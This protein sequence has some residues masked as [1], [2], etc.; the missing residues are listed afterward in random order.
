MARGQR[1]FDTVRDK[2]LGVEVQV[3]II[4]GGEHRGQFS[5][6][7]ADQEFREETFEEL[8]TKLYASISESSTLTWFPI[9]EVKTN[10]ENGS[11]HWGS[12]KLGLSLE[13]ERYYVCKRPDGSFL[14]CKWDIP[15]K[16]R[17]RNGSEHRVTD[18]GRGKRPDRSIDFTN[19]P[20]KAQPY[21]YSYRD[22]DDE[23]ERATHYLDYD[24]ALF[25]GL[26]YIGGQVLKLE[27]KLGEIIGSK[28]GRDLLVSQ[29]VRLLP[30][31]TA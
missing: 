30:E 8:K 27:E 15:E 26:E 7:Y 29:A 2:D 18:H 21:R 4:T 13:F 12:K 6:S 25:Q 24:E 14:R 5:A 11:G 28:R 16:D 22:E 3:Y 23:I 31:K 19:L 9:L 10:R 1:K 17:V 20:D